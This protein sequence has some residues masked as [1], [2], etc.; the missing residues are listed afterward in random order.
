VVQPLLGD[1][2]Q[3]FRVTELHPYLTWREN[4]IFGRAET[5]THRGGHLLDQTIL[6]VVEAEGLQEWLTRLGLEFEVGRLGA[7]CPA[8]KAS[9]WRSRGRSCAAHRC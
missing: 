4:L 3:P 2:W 6:E 5:R 1:A 9:S 7:I 8:A